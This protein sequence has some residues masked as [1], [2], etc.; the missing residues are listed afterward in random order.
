M[1]NQYIHS[2]LYT[3]KK[4]YGQ[5][6]TLRKITDAVFNPVTGETDTVQTERSIQRALVLEQDMYVEV[7]QQL[8]VKYGG[9]FTVNK[10]LVIIETKDFVSRDENG[11]IIL[12]EY[13][14]NDFI[15]VNGEEFIIE[16][17]GIIQNGKAHF[18]ICKKIQDGI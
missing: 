11:E 13:G 18:F 1:F 16:D 2:Q 3:L 12:V 9:E 4:F 15:L 5:P 7:G 17:R 8:S 14:K 10:R 6:C